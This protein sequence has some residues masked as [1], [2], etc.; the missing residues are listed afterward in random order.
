[1]AE[2]ERLPDS[3]DTWA[4]A[5]FTDPS[6][7]YQVDRLKETEALKKGYSWHCECPAWRF[8]HSGDR[9]CKHIY[10]V[11]DYLVYHNEE[12]E[13]HGQK[14]TVMEVSRRRIDMIDK[15]GVF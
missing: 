4:I 2:I 3:V 14:F 6:K 7:K 1:M 15:V 8:N 9:M 12:V 13:V 11:Q 5:S 10:A